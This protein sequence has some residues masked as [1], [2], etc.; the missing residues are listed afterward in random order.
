MRIPENATAIIQDLEKGGFL[1]VC[2][3]TSMG[4]DVQAALAEIFTTVKGKSGIFIFVVTCTYCCESLL[5]GASKEE[6]ASFV[7]KL[8]DQGRYVQELWSV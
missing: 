7:K 2:G 1:Y 6:A 5:I 4:T 3:A 8:Q